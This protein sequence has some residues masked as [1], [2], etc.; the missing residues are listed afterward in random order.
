MEDKEKC[1]RVH[2]HFVELISTINPIAFHSCETRQSCSFTCV[3]T[4][5]KVSCLFFPFIPI[6]ILVSLHLFIF[7]RILQVT[8]Y[9]TYRVLF[10]WAFAL[11]H[12]MLVRVC[13]PLYVLNIILLNMLRLKVIFSCWQ[14]VVQYVKLSVLLGVNHIILQSALMMPLW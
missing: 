7:S 11:L 8:W 4:D 14:A 1:W 9:P 12:A 13:H 5:C 2:C 3:C 10:F 6:S